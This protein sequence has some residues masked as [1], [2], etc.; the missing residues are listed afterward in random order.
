MARVPAFLGGS[1]VTQSPIFN[2]EFTINW[3]PERATREGDKS[4]VALYPSAGFQRLATAST[5]PGRGSLS[6][7]WNGVARTFMV[8]GAQLYEVSN[9]GLLTARGTPMA[10]DANPATL[11]FNGASGGQLFVTSGDNGYILDLNTN[12][13]S[14]VRTGGTTMGEFID[15]YFLALD[16][17]TSTLYVSDLLDGTVWDPTQ[18]AQNSLTQDGWISLKVNYQDIWLMGPQTSQ[19]WQDAGTFPFPFQPRPGV[20]LPV[21]IAAPFSVKKVGDSILWVSRTLNGQGTVM[22]A[23]GYTPQPV[24]TPAID[25]AIEG[26]GRIGDA[27]GDADE[28]SGHV[29]YLVHFPRAKATLQFDVTV[30]PTSWVN[31]G[32]WISEQNQFE[33]MRQMY[34][35]FTGSKH[36]W[37]DRKTGDIYQ[38]SPAYGTDADDRLMRRLRRGPS[39]FRE[40]K[41]IFTGAF[42]LFLEAGL[43][44]STGHG[45]DP[46]VMLRKSNDGGKTWGPERHASAGKIGQYKKRCLFTR[47]GMG[48]DVVFEVSVTDPIPWR[49]VDAFVELGR[50]QAA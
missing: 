35:V 4:P 12:G 47:T 45:S 28:V 38:S 25:Y 43:G 2:Q 5:A 19:V 8:M 3:W 37:A 49:L 33:S 39:V 18:F 10:V 6:I 27:V 16:S 21:G 40:H 17:L 50:G 9:T 15:G 32:T 41:R 11:S 1:N 14:Q 36:L 24:S 48:R 29:F 44:T 22:Q 30:G 23:S 42:E 7:I 46:K 34:H 20:V 31:R 26:F 13:F